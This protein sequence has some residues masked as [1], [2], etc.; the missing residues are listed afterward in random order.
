[1]PPVVRYAKYPLALR[2]LALCEERQIIAFAE[3]KGFAGA[4]APAASTGL[5]EEGNRGKIRALT[6]TRGLKRNLFRSM[7]NVNRE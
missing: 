4:S 7:S 5:P 6:G 1:M 2:P 3:E